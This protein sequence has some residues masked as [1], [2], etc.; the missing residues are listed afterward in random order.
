MFYFITYL[1]EIR[2]IDFNNCYVLSRFSGPARFHT[3][4]LSLCQ[5][6]IYH[7]CRSVGPAC[8]GHTQHATSSHRHVYTGNNTSPTWTAQSQT[9]KIRKNFF[10]VKWLIW[11][12]KRF[13]KILSVT[14]F[15]CVKIW[16][17]EIDNSYD[18]TSA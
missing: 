14:S 18:I 8:S 5:S 10:F 3:R 4:P 9:V 13:S 12:W 16:T 17:G 7:G 1:V 2:D 15:F 11:F 6:P